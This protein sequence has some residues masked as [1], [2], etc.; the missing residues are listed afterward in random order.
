[1]GHRHHAHPVG[2]EAVANRAAFFQDRQVQQLLLRNP[3]TPVPLIRRMLGA[4]RLLEIYKAGQSR[5]LPDKNRVVTR[6]LLRTRWNS[7]SGDEKVE[8]IVTTEGR[9]LT[10][11]SG[12]ALDGK[13]VAMLCARTYASVQLIQNLA[14]WAAS[15]PPLIAHLIKQ[16]MVRRMPQLKALLSRHPNC[17]PNVD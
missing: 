16:P 11:L 9:C 3:Q 2:L 8:L 5:D 13:A 7:A 14:H 4:R 15:P 10:A 12:L 17:P 6:E 1:V